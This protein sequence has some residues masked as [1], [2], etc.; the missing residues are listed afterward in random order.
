MPVFEW[1]DQLRTGIDTIDAQHLKLVELVNALADAMRAG[2]GKDVIG[3]V[4]G[5]LKDYTEY[6]FGFEEEAFAK[7]GFPGAAAHAKSHADLVG[8]LEDLAGKYSRGVIGISIDILDF[9]VGWVKNH[10]MK[11]DM[12]YV[13]FLKGKVQ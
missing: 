5:E 12:E 9:L 1:S 8:Q 7:H 11:E 4:L 6:H 13:P 3:K 2:K 10:I